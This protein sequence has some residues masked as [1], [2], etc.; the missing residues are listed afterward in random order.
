[1]RFNRDRAGAPHFLQ[2]LSSDH[3]AIS[4]NHGIALDCSDHDRGNAMSSFDSHARGYHG[5]RQ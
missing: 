2:T 5:K 1:M 3:L 4:G